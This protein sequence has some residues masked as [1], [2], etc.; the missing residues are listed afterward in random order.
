MLPL[1]FLTFPYMCGSISRLPLF[2][3]IVQESV[4][5]PCVE[6]ISSY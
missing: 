4:N 1:P 6:T 3:S 2:C 5:Y